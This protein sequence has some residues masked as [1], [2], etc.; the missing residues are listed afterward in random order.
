MR[1]IKLYLARLL[2]FMML[3]SLV[4]GDFFVKE[5]KAAE[6]EYE[7]YTIE[8]KQLLNSLAYENK[9]ILA[10]K[11]IDSE[12]NQKITVSLVENGKE[13]IL[14]EVED[15]Y[16]VD[17]IESRSDNTVAVALLNY[18]DD[19]SKNEYKKIN[20]N[21][22]KIYDITEEE[23]NSLL[24]YGEE[25]SKV[26]SDDE[27]EEVLQK[28]NNKTGLN[29]TI[30]DKKLEGVDEYYSEYVNGNERIY[31]DLSY[32][33]NEKSVIEFYVNYTNENISE[34]YSGLIF[35]DY[36]FIRTNEITLQ[37]I[38]TVDNGDL[39][40]FTE[41]DDEFSMNFEIIKVT[42]DGVETHRSIDEGIGIAGAYM[43]VNG[44][45]LY[46]SQYVK[47]GYIPT[48]NIYQPNGD[49][50]ELVNSINNIGTVS[51]LDGNSKILLSLNDEKL[52]LVKLTG[53]NTEVLYDLS[54]V[55]VGE[56]VENYTYLSGIENNYIFDTYNGEAPC[57]VVMQKNTPNQPFVPEVP[58]T[59]E[60]PDNNDNVVIKPSDDKVVAEV[61]KINPNEKNEINVNTDSL[62]KK[63]DITIK[64]VESLKNG[65]GSLNITI[66]NGVQLNLPLSVIDK[67]L[68]EGAKDVTIRLDV[69]ENSEILKDI[70]G[71][72]KVF[73][74]NLIVS[75]E[76]GSTFIHNFKDGQ[77][78]IIISLADKDLEG[79]NKDNI[80][81]YYYN[82]AEKNFEAMETKVD[83]NKVTF[84]TSHF[85][86][87]VIAEK[88]DDSNVIDKNE[89]KTEPEDKNNTETGKETLPNT[90]AVVSSSVIFA[91]GVA[92]VVGGSMLFRKKRHA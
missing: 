22:K 1:K 16:Q 73:D 27:K 38:Y 20:L 11:S 66:N 79:L 36:V 26:W 67:S 87:Y 2:T 55:L 71:V 68:L 48:L 31:I 46:I 80:V 23:Y 47:D 75:K 25:D 70:K 88:L 39:Y 78:E 77:A 62:V 8:N 76:D 28:I 19:S 37:P 85:S 54:D 60:T 13:T 89:N 86:K 7:F 58:E 45:Y 42:K 3:I 33:N 6:G 29:L 59:P 56:Y 30:K 57:I 14:Y 64:D 90:G 21:E 24:E 18:G 51:S 5:V 41:T 12:N 81:V 92:A 10:Y 84:I 34:H 40:I 91:L 43:E 52:E 35:G 50:Y 9:M 53:A 69:I 82:D 4:S 49:R 63:V 17:L 83:G 61:S 74:F 65:T 32:R 44:E 72:N 15:S